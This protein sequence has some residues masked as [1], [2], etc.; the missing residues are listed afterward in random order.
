M[1]NAKIEKLYKGIPPISFWSTINDTIAGL[2]HTF[3]MVAKMESNYSTFDT[4]DYRRVLDVSGLA[5]L[6]V[7]RVSKGDNGLELSQALQDNVKKTLLCDKVPY[8]TAKQAACVVVAD[9]MTMKSTPM[10]VF[11][12]GFD[13]ISNLV[14]SADVH[15]GLMD[16]ESKGVRAFTLITGISADT[17]GKQGA[18]V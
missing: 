8:A 1:D 17:F 15:R 10:D 14:P 9:K 18:Y 16:S 12:Y 3:N 11:N 5:V 6:G 13:M 7:T 2:F 4:E